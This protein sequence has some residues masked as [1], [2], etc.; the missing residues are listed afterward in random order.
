MLTGSSPALKNLGIFAQVFDI[1]GV[2]NHT[3]ASMLKYMP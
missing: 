2:T 1:T 3:K